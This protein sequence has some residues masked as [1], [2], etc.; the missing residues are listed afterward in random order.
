MIGPGCMTMASRLG[1]LQAR[2][3]HL[4]AGDVVLQADFLSRQ[5]FFLHAQQHDHIGAAQRVF[6]V[7]R[8]AQAGR[9]RGGDVGHELGRAAER[10]LHSE[11]CVSRWQAL[12]ATRL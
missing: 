4:V 10:E 9:K 8:D 2:R 5:A 1:Q 12:R 7:A 6:D 3:G 11:T